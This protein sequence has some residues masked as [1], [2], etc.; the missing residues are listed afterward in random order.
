MKRR[1][2]SLASRLPDYRLLN[3]RYSMRFEPQDMD[4]VRPVPAGLTGPIRLVALR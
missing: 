3:L 1:G 2:T 4:K